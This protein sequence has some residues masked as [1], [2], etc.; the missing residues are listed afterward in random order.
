MQTLI[1][2]LPK[3]AS[4]VGQGSL[5]LQMAWFAAFLPSAAPPLPAGVRNDHLVSEGMKGVVHDLHLYGVVGRE[6]PQGA[7]DTSS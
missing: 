7:W 1:P 6:V 2:E 4:S 3:A 5:P